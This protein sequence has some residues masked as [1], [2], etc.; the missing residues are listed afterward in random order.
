MGQYNMKWFKSKTVWL[1]ILGVGLNLLNAYTP[2][3]PAHVMQYINPAI[4]VGTA[5]TRTVFANPD[6]NVPPKS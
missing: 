6:L 5:L 3:I 1:S 4:G 2:I